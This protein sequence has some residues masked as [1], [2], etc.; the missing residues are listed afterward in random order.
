[1]DAIGKYFTDFEGFKE[2][3]KKAVQDRATPGWV[4]LGLEASSGRLLV[5]QTNN[6]DNPLMHGVVDAQCIPLIGIDL[7]EHAYLADFEGDKDAYTDAF[8]SH[9]DWGQVSADFETFNLQGKPT[10]VN[11]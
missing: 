3:F 8:L 1:M 10:P 2:A 9:V 5:T 11:N 4:W 6:E 7:W